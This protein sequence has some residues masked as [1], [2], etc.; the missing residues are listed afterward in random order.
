MFIIDI[1][2]LVKCYQILKRVKHL[3][4]RVFNLDDFRLN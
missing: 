1:W 4:S 3:E 2:I